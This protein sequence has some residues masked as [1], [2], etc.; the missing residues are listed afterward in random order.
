MRRVVLA[1]GREHRRPTP[2]PLK[3]PPVTFVTLA[4]PDGEVR[5]DQGQ[6][7]GG[8]DVRRVRPRPKRRCEAACGNGLRGGEGRRRVG[9]VRSVGRQEKAQER[10]Q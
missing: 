2:L 8:D 10:G 6:T 7:V 4:F 9:T 5:P 1:Q 3:A